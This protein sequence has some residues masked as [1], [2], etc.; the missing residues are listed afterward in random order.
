M[1]HYYLEHYSHGEEK[2]C[3]QA[4][5]CVG[6]NK[7][8][9]MTSY[10]AWRVTTGRSKSCELNFMLPGHTK[11][12]PDRFFGLLKRNYRH[13]GVSP[14]AEIVK[15]VEESTQGGQNKAFVIGSEPPS[16]RFYYYDW[17]QFLSS[18]YNHISH[19][20]FYHHFYFSKE[21]PEEVAVC[22]FADKEEMKIPTLKPDAS[23]NNSELPPTLSPSGL[24][25]QRQQYLF[26]EIRVFCDEKYQDI[27]CPEPLTRK[28]PIDQ[29]SDGTGPSTKKTKRLY[30]H[31]R[32]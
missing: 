4:D 3:L 15:V 26:N 13:T 19:I 1:V 9:I 31:C 23:I 28:C 8:N 24:S 11:F 12:S 17:A 5:K 29:S 30:S 32:H 14:L 18:Y 20:T 16:K 22:E 10:L 21:H 25:E 7:N 27:T 6:Q 2:I